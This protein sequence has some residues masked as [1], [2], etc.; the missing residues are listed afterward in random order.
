MELPLIARRLGTLNQAPAVVTVGPKVGTEVRLIPCVD[1]LTETA[2]PEEVV[3]LRERSSLL[4]RARR[5]DE[6]SWAVLW[7]VAVTAVVAATRILDGHL[8]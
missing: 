5:R 8:L 2:P 4:L 7:W 1:R 6:A 3:M